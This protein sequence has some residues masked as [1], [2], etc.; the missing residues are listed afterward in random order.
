MLPGF[1]FLFAAIVLSMSILVFGLGAAALLRAAHEEFASTPSWHAAPE[2]N[3]AQQGEATGPVL[4]MLRVDPLVAEHKTPDEAE[5]MAAPAEQPAI[6]PTPVEPEGTAMPIA[7]EKTAA[8]RPNDSPPLETAK[9]ETVTP[10][11]VTPEIPVAESPPQ[12]EATPAQAVAAVAVVETKMATL[13]TPS[14]EAPSEEAP[15]P[16]SNVAPPAP[17]QA[18]APEQISAPASATPSS[19]DVA[20]TKIATLGGPP[21]AIEE[22]PAKSDVAKHDKSL[23]K[24]HVEERRTKRHRRI[25]SRARVAQQQPSDPFSQPVVAGRRR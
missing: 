13:E 16:A 7:S 15:S 21:V 11:I 24:K 3:F 14:E 5:Q 9:P 18:S 12:Q 23:A 25:A 20:S 10:E 1:R 2:T 22:P 8:L 6:L 17:E 19:A 4:A